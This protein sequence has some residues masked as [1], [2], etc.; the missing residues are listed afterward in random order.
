MTVG[1]P[2]MM[3]TLPAQGGMRVRGLNL[4]VR[5]ARLFR[6]I[7]EYAKSRDQFG[8]QGQPQARFGADFLKIQVRTGSSTTCRSE[9]VKRCI[10]YYGRL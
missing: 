1:R 3:F 9:H 5:F 10:F 4:S 2:Q 7:R 8:D 6:I